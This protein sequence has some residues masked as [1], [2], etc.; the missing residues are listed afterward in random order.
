MITFGVPLPVVNRAT[1]GVFDPGFWLKLQL[2]IAI[3]CES[4]IADAARYFPD[5]EKAS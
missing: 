3:E 4:S 5:D 1:G 2:K